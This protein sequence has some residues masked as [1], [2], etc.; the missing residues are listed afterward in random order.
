MLAAYTSA[1]RAWLQEQCHTQKCIAM[2]TGDSAASLSGHMT[3]Q[4]REELCVA[5][6]AAQES[7]I[8]QLL[9]EICLPSPEDEKVGLHF[10]TASSSFFMFS[11]CLGFT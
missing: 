11:C 3:K 9:L 10:P 4:E 5:L 2:T 1:S 8:V 7:A 6:I